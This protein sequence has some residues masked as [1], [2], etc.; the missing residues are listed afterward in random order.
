MS[1]TT[2]FVPYRDVDVRHS[3]DGHNDACFSG[4]SGASQTAGSGRLSFRFASTAMKSAL[5]SNWQGNRQRRRLIRQV[6]LRA[7]GLAFLWLMLNGDDAASWF[8]GLP[9]VTA[10]TIASLLFQPV[11]GWKLNWRGLAQ[12][13]P[14]FLWESLRGSVDVA[15]RAL[16]PQLPLAPLL[17]DYELR[18]PPGAWRV[19]L[20]NSVSLLPGTLSAELQGDCLTVHALDGSQESVTKKLRSLEAR[21]A[22]LFGLPQPSDKSVVRTTDE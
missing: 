11:V 18:L 7:A 14:F 16:H 19:F 10:A 5:E 15:K 21:I 8:I 3:A 13:L 9:A 17:V 2:S 22:D 12:F 1:G 6:A 4:A 20:A